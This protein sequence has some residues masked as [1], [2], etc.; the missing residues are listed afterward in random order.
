MKN[1]KIKNPKNQNFEI[2]K[3]SVRIFHGCF[4]KSLEQFSLKLS[5]ATNGTH[6]F[7]SGEFEGDLSSAFHI[8]DNLY[9]YP[10]GFDG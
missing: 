9:Q 8:G 6:Y 5:E 2:Q 4:V 10:V 7:V 3:K 1:P